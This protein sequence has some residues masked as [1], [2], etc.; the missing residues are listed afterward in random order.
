MTKITVRLGFVPTFRFHASA[1]VQKMRADSLAAFARVPGLEIV[2]PQPSPDG[3][4]DPARGLTP[5]GMVNTFEQAE[6]VAEYF[7][8]QK[9]DG[10]I[11]CPLDF[12]DERSS[13]KVAELLA[14]LPVLLYATKEPPA[15][16]DA[17][18]SR[19]SDSYCGNLSLAAGLTRR[20][21]AFRYAGLFFPEEPELLAEVNAFVSAVAVVKNLRGARIGQ[22]GGR[23]NSFETVAYDEIAMVQKF[24][25]NVIHAEL[26]DLVD[27]A[28]KYAEGDPALAERVA[29]IRAGA[30]TI[31]VSDE[32]LQNAAR[33]ELALADF[34]KRNRL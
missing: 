29:F 33:L 15:V 26:S 11:I 8:S 13:V 10:L 9:V 18:L 17:G 34:W 31:T 16:D 24:G 7:R 25:Q 22:I 32:Y 5:Y 1:W 14:P 19:A 2:V 27:V 20:K 30:P 4:C 12:G 28:Q 3:G 6:A 21:I 23:P